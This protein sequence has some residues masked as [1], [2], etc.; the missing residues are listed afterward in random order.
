MGAVD[1]AFAAVLLEVAG[2]D[3]PAPGAGTFLR[4]LRPAPQ[5]R[6]LPRRAGVGDPVPAL[7]AGLSDDCR[8]SA[9]AW[10]SLLGADARSRR[11]GNC[12]ANMFC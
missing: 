6:Y 8:F 1:L 7:C 5:W 10:R 12:C 9:D 2:R 3:A 4:V 11:R